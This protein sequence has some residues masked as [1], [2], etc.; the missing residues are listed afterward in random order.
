MELACTATQ[1]GLTDAQTRGVSGFFSMYHVTDRI[2]SLHNGGCIGGDEEIA[3]IAYSFLP[4]I[5]IILH[6]GDTPKKW[7][8]RVFELASEIFPHRGNLERNR[9]M[10]DIAT[11]V[12]ACPREGTEVLR[13]GTWATIRYAKKTGKRLTIIYPSGEIEEWN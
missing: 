11:H 8:T 13:S 12:L 7:S 1:H 9:Y 10:V 5:N 4:R 3:E 2:N 6:P